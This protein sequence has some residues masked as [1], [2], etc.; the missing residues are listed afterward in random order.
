MTAFQRSLS[1]IGSNE[2]VAGY[3]FIMPNFLGFLVFT[4][5]PVLASLGL[6]FVEWDLLT[7]AKFVGFANFVK[8]LGFH[9]DA[10]QLVA[11]NPEFWKYM[12]N[13]VFLMLVIPF[14]MAGSLALALAANQKLKGI[15]F[16]RTVFFLPTVCAG[17]ALLLLW[18]WIYNPDFGPLN[19]LLIQVFD[20]LHLGISPP[21]WLSSTAWAKPAIMLMGFWGAIGGMNMILYLAALQNVPR[22]L[23][24]AAE[25]D[26]ATSWRKFWAVSLPYLSPTTFFVFI[27]SVIAGLQGG[28]MQAYV[29][30][31]GGPA[32]ATTTI[33]YYIY[34]NAYEWGH[35]G[36]AAAA[37]WVLFILVFVVTLINWRMGG[38]LVHY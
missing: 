11:N 29:L 10:G 21:D 16:F 31:K 1:A 36:D 12:Y 19:S 35:M 2:K 22:E 13:T 9:R 23:Y 28:F 24:E 25:I 34:K 27:T 15:T 6:S 18:K 4:S 32:G 26:G 30:T 14:N 37:A 5:L 3:V 8:L 38:R 33:D 17:V 20:L 7:P